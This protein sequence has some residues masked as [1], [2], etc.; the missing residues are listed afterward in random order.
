MRFGRPVRSLTLVVL[1]G[2]ALLCPPAASAQS[3]VGGG[4][5]T[6]TLPETEPTVGVL[7]VGGVRFAPGLTVQEIGWDSN[8]FDEPTIKSPKEDFVAA[9]QPDVSAFARLR[10]FRISAYAGSE[11]TYYRKYES[12]RSVGHAARARVDMLL[13]RVRPFIGIGETETRTRPNGEIDTRADR[14]ETELSGG[15]AFDLSPNSLVYGSAFQAKTTYENAFE[16][17]VDLGRSMTRESD[18]YQ[19]GLKTDITSLLSVQLFAS[20][21]DDRFEF[22]PI[23]N[24]ESW[25]GTATFRF[26]PDAV[27]SGLVTISYR[28]MSFVDP[29]VSPYRGLV[30]TVSLI[31]PVLEIGRL[32]VALTRG[33]EYSFDTQEAYYLQQSATVAYTHRLFGEVDA[34]VRGSWA[35]FDYDAR[36]NLPSHTDTLDMAGG[37]I[38]YNLRNRTRIALNYEYARRRSPAFADRNYERRRAFLSWQF[39]F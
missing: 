8:V 9:V 14:Q 28:D 30:G 39:A 22:E 20:Y 5:L 6:S 36:I 19:G 34:Q 38:G 1:T 32:S 15:L 24:A 29:E 13:S 18:N 35:S 12:E 16:D 23:R 4:P 25:L 17:G 37:S 11:L 10:L 27:V 7:T 33:V 3:S 26:A 21:Q 2:M 31:Y